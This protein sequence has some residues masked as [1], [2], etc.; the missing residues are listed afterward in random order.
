MESAGTGPVLTWD[1]TVLPSG[2]TFDPQSELL[3]WTPTFEQKGTYPITFH[4][5]DDG[6]STVTPTSD[7]V[8]V[9]IDVRHA[10]ATRIRLR[11]DFNISGLSVSAHCE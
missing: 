4:V 5:T 3:S 7:T 6:D 11:S 9:T 1:H 2:A 8:T 10:D